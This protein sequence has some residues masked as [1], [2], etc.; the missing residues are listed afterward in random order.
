MTER[1]DA[2]IYAAVK[3]DS[4]D[5]KSLEGQKRR[6]NPRDQLYKKRLKEIEDKIRRKLSQGL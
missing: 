6:L 1:F 2:N 3:K 5:I 4:G